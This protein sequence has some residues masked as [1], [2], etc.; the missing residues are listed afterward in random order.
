MPPKT[1]KD[2]QPHEVE[3]IQYLR[4]NGEKRL[5]YAPIG[6]DYVEKSKDMILSAE[7]LPTG[8]VAIFCRFN[9]EDETNEHLLLAKNG[10][11]PNSPNDTLRKIIDIKF[12]ERNGS[13][14]ATQQ[15][16]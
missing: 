11:G 8:M 6:I 7:W 1:P 9:D 15:T 13:N 14:V 2:R 16:S 3:I 12:N 4:P 10:P 5:M